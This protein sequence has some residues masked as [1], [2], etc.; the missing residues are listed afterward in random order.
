MF[1]TL[2]GRPLQFLEASTTEHDEARLS[3]AKSRNRIDCM[4]RFVSPPTASLIATVLA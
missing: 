1:V 4:P 3:P 2:V